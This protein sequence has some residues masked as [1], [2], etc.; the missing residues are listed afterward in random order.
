[1][2]R[3]CAHHNHVQ[4][5]SVSTSVFLVFVLCASCVAVHYVVSLT[6]YHFS[7]R[8]IH[9][10]AV[11]V[12]DPCCGFDSLPMVWSTSTTR[13]IF[14]HLRCPRLYAAPCCRHGVPKYRHPNHHSTTQTANPKLLY[15]KVAMRYQ[16]TTAHN[17][18][19]RN[20]IVLQILHTRKQCEQ[21]TNNKTCT[22]QRKHGDART[23]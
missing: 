11:H 6:R 14:G 13:E 17:A 5:K 1:M 22:V 15:H 21:S 3:V 23:L 10:Q 20:H 7:R 16:L 9:T 12:Q 8:G 4:P 2:Q 19:R 18:N